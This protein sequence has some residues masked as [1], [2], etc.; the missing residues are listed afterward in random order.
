MESW[1]ESGE[2]GG[3]EVAGDRGAVLSSDAYFHQPDGSYVFN[4]DKLEEA[5]RLN[6]QRG[7]ALP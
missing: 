6:F 2:V 7:P 3:R 4:P 1:R 5:H